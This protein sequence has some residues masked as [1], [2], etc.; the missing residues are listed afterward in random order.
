M[1]NVDEVFRLLPQPDDLRR[2]EKAYLEGTTRTD[3][4][5]NEA[6]DRAALD[7]GRRIRA[8]DRSRTSLKEIVAWKNSESRF[9]NRIEQQ[10]ET[11]N[12]DQSISDALDMVV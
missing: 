1:A 3:K 8:G 9:W 10:F 7:A 12:N 5:T 11:N 4:K 6:A 2:L